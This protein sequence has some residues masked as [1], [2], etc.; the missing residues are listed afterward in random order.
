MRHPCDLQYQKKTKNIYNKRVWCC[1]IKIAQ[2]L[3]NKCGYGCCKF[4]RLTQKRMNSRELFL[5][6]ARSRKT[7][8]SNLSKMGK[9][10][11]NP[12][13]TETC[14]KKGFTDS[15][16]LS[17]QVTIGWPN[18]EFLWWEPNPTATSKSFTK[19]THHS[20]A[21]ACWSCLCFEPQWHEGGPGLYWTQS[22]WLPV[23]LH[24]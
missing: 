21:P 6:L 13:P 23:W 17:H 7:N 8:Y 19:S 12:F 11:K 15:Q 20:P 3:T 5:L 1:S 2:Q 24:G 22:C 9:V 14:Q 16:E 10:L 4:W 18:K